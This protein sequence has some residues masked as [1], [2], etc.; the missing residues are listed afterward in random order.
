MLMPV[1]A[2]T[3]RSAQPRASRS[4]FICRPKWVAGL[5]PLFTDMRTMLPQQRITVTDCRI[6]VTRPAAA[7]RAANPSNGS[8]SG[9]LCKFHSLRE[10]QDDQLRRLYEDD[11][12]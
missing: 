12:S 1:W 3:S 10:I 11:R 9:A 5:P 6:V 2:E 8:G 4:F 7:E